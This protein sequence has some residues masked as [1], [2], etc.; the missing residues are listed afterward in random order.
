MAIQSVLFN[1]ATWT[2]PR[3]RG[4]LIR[5]GFTAYKVHTTENYH[6]FRQYDPRREKYRTQKI[7][8]GIEYVIGYPM[9]K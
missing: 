7:G 4:W 1:R 6:R 3:A 5:N 9:R 2:V 8:N